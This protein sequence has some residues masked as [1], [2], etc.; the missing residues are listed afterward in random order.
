MKTATI[1]GCLASAVAFAPHPSFHRLSSTTT[2]QSFAAKVD[3]ALLFDCDGVILETEEL[4][5]LAYNAA[6]KAADLTIDGEPVEWTVKYYG[7]F[8]TFPIG[9]DLRFIRSTNNVPRMKIKGWV[10]EN[11]LVNGPWSQRNRGCE[12]FI[13]KTCGMT[14]ASVASASRVADTT[15]HANQSITWR[16]Q[17]VDF[18]STG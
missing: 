16:R 11:T 8:S 7:E 14:S 6:F 15:V 4:H 10:Q 17:R 13:G 1:L 9:M 12:N 2:T 3:F 18:I 5:R